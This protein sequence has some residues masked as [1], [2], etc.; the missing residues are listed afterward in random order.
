MC[1]ILGIT[2]GN[3]D[4]ETK[5]SIEHFKYRGPD[6]TGVWSDNKISFAN[7]RLSIIDP[8]EAS[9]QPMF[10]DDGN[11]GVVFNGEIYNYK[12]IKKNLT[13]FDFKTD[14]DC[15]VI[16]YA[17]KKW[18]QKCFERFYG[19]FAICIYDKNEGKLIL[20][21][22][23]AGIKP[24]YYSI[25]ET[26]LSLAFASEIKGILN[27]KRKTNFLIN[28]DVILNL[29][30]LGFIESPK[31]LYK[32]IHKLGRA[33][34]LEFNL[35][36]K[37]FHINHYKIKTS[38]E[39]RS[40]EE[41]L[42]NS[43]ARH[44]VSDVPVGLFFSG[45][46]DS[47]IIASLLKKRNINMNAYSIVM[48]HKSIDEKYILPIASELNL[49]LKTFKFDTKEFDN[50]YLEVMKKIDE[51]L[52]DASIFPTYF[53]SKIASRE[54]KVVLS[55]EGG[56]EYFLGYDRQLI[57][58]NLKN[59][60]DYTLNIFDYIYLLSPNFKGKKKMFEKIFINF[61]KPLSYFLLKMSIFEKI[62]S[63]KHFKE[64]IKNKNIPYTQI[65][66]E[67]Y[68]ENDLL[69]KIDFATSYASLEGRVPLLDPEVIAFANNIKDSKKLKDNVLK[70]NLKKVLE[71]Y[72]RTEYIYR[73]KSGFSS[74]LSHFFKNSKL[75]STDLEKSL[76]Y[77]KDKEFVWKHIKNINFKN[78]SKTNPYFCFTL[79]SLYYSLNNNQI[80]QH[81]QIH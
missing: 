31:T 19:M 3:M 62:T 32:G 6:D 15:E 10:S 25:D 39:N 14:G 76:T 2:V 49:N 28:D 72:L 67:I 51:P 65:D 63:W 74:P 80:S 4:F 57:L 71:N 48:P 64:N 59:H 43:I 42:D 44:L 50:I 29:L 75:L 7:V 5:Q 36:T 60:P 77:F 22:D 52:Y 18:G 56:D 46:T 55:G 21:R 61:K 47:S 20:A 45:G 8:H 26:N 66:K 12:E 35:R 11:I 16:I 34:I 78:L 17:Y 73:D 69:R 30:T 58:N 81:G 40:L 37:E 1:G 33:E 53:V 27:L 13:E 9:N 23:H 54:V 68:L 79:I 41:I 38:I 24:L 70:Y